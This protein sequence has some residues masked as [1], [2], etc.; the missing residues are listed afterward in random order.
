VEE[1]P[2]YDA[3]LTPMPAL[4]G[5]FEMEDL[6][7]GEAQ[8]PEDSYGPP[9]RRRIGW[10]NNLARSPT[11]PRFPGYVDFDPSDNFNRNRRGALLAEAMEGLQLLWRGGGSPPPPVEVELALAASPV[12]RASLQGLTAGQLAASAEVFAACGVHSPA[13]ADACRETMRDIAREAIRKLSTFGHE[14]LRTLRAAALHLDVLDPYLERA[15]RRRFP[16]ALRNALRS[17]EAAGSPPNPLFESARPAGAAKAHEDGASAE[18][19][20]SGAGGKTEGAE[21]AAQ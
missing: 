8:S 21:K 7:A 6:E 19:P 13:N 15:R 17:E 10:Y 9:Q 3:V 1:A 12:L 4:G 5:G 14:D 2:L 16:K 11:L 20:G 18:Q